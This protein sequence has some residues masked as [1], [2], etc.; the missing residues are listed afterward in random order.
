VALPLTVACAATPVSVKRQVGEASRFALF[1]SKQTE[2]GSPTSYHITRHGSDGASP[3]RAS[4]GKE[5]IA[6]SL[7]GCRPEKIRVG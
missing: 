1:G 3:F 7:D 6:D 5:G 4:P 2:T